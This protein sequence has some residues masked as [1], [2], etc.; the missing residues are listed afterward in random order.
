ME[1]PKG[2]D[3]LICLSLE[4]TRSQ[5]DYR[6]SIESQKE[7]LINKDELMKDPKFPNIIEI[8]WI[9]YW[10]EDQKPEKEPNVHFV[11]PTNMEH[12]NSK[13]VE[14]TGVT[15][16]D[17]EQAESLESVLTKFNNFVF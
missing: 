16:E 5:G 14:T 9:S 6:E 13:T 11:K 4:T 7:S 3:Y 1:T 12:L 2:Y 8:N 17:I 10:V 15:E